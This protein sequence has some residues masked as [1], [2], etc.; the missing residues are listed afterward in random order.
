MSVHRGK[1]SLMVG[2]AGA[3]RNLFGTKSGE[4]FCPCTRSLM[5]EASWWY[6]ARITPA[7]IVELAVPTASPPPAAPGDVIAILTVWISR[8]SGRTIDALGVVAWAGDYLLGH[9]GPCCQGKSRDSAENF[10]F[11]QAFLHS[12]AVTRVRFSVGRAP[13]LDAS[14]LVPRSGTFP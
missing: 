14:D 13:I 11:H 12:V 6:I 9:C 7:S 1:A 10:E 3:R 5:P 2:R 4:D 8:F